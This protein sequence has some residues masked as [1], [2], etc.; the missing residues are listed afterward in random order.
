MNILELI[1]ELFPLLSYQHKKNFY[2]LQILVLIMAI[3]ELIGIASIGPF[4]ALAADIELINKNEILNYIYVYSGINSKENFLFFIGVIVLFLLFISSIFSIVTTWKL[5][6]FGMTVG[7]QMGDRLYK[8]YLSKDWLFHAS[9]SSSK[10]T[11]KITTETNRLT[12]GIIMHLMYLNSKIILAF[13]ISISI[14]LYNPV[15]AI[16]GLII[17]FTGYFIIYKSIKNN[18]S[19]FGTSISKATSNRF[20]LMNEGFG[21]IKDIILLN[22]RDNFIKKFEDSGEKL[23]R[24]QGLITALGGTPK[25]FMELLAFGTMILL[26]LVLIKIH[27]GNI[28][29]VLPV[30]SVYALAGFKLLPAFQQIYSS[31]ASIKGN[32]SAFESIKDDL[33]SSLLFDEPLQNDNN[34]K[35]ET[36]NTIILEEVS[37]KYPNKKVSALNNISLKIKRNSIVG[38]VGESGSGKSTTVDIILGLI[39]PEKGYLAIDD[40]IINISNRNTWQKNIGFVPQSIF[41]SEGTI[42]QNIAFGLSDEQI[43][44]EKVKKSIKLAHLDELVDSLEEGL[45]TRVGER[46][47]KLSGGQRQRIGIARALYNDSSVLVFDEATSALDGITEKIIMDAIHELNGQK[48]IILIAHRLKTVKKCDSIFIFEKG[49]IIDNGTYDELI[50]KNKLFKKM[51]ENA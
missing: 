46:G 10:L 42:S 4:M 38:F 22:R 16:F 28:S 35:I 27:D 1:K 37:F 23:A 12:G 47:V 39:M 17:F 19:K 18:L 5:S 3:F 20:R 2:I 50:A 11:N 48:T 32:I 43:D 44:L 25:Y 40:K 34:F 21:G 51:V 8:Y 13:F 36:F 49:R 6:V 41:L 9:G 33:K 30:L 29:E 45:D 7:T 24:A 15:V 14:L 31:I 26:V